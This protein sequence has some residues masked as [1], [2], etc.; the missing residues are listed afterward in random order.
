MNEREINLW[1]LLCD[2]LKHWRT[3]VVWMIVGGLLL[4]GY[5]YY[6]NYKAAYAAEES[7]RL[8]QTSD[9]AVMAEAVSAGGNGEISDLEIGNVEAVIYNEWAAQSRLDQMKKS[10]WASMDEDNVYTVKLEYLISSGAESG[11]AHLAELYDSNGAEEFIGF[12]TKD[13]KELG[14]KLS[15]DLFIISH[16]EKDG[17]VEKT[18]VEDGENPAVPICDALSVSLMADT[19]E[20][21]NFLKEEF[22]KYMN[23]L[24]R[25][26]SAT[27]GKHSIEL[28]NSSVI[29]GY[30]EA[31]FSKKRIL[32]SE[33]AT[34]TLNGGKAKDAFDDNEKAYYTVRK[35]GL[36]KD[37]AIEKL[38]ELKEQKN[39][40]KTT[41][42]STEPIKVKGTL[43]RKF[44]LIGLV[45]FAVL[46]AGLRF[47]AY[48]FSNKIKVC[49]DIEGL[50]GITRLSTIYHE[51]DRKLF[52]GIDEAIHKLRYKNQRIFT[53]DAAVNITSSAIKL[54]AKKN[55]LDTVYLLGCGLDTSENSDAKK[56][57]D[58]LKKDNI[59]IVALCD[60]LYDPQALECLKDAKAAVLLEKAE[61][62]MYS[63]VLKERDLLKR[64][65]I[66]LLGAVITE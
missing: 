59:N 25:K 60:V 65:D 8:A 35:S 30:N 62:T 53:R 63:E 36:E 13:N 38:A 32:N 1:D 28:I 40:I 24:S 17:K 11:Y 48:I 23:E 10:L 9:D 51:S 3:L 45:G 50:Y 16:W 43:S 58:K 33:M 42:V 54:L 15:A 21:A 4:G 61:S 12:V 56:I 6:R 66:K 19:E 31:A 39:E 55:E 2:I 5:G 22:G 20:N 41:A 7:R 49:D 64:Q 27:T 37:E 57:S 46:Y 18:T 29:S 47:L 14:E 26:I 44:L 52:K 34:Y